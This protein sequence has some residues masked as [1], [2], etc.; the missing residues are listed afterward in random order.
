MLRP[1]AIFLPLLVHLVL[2]TTYAYAADPLCRR[3]ISALG[4]CCATQCGQCGGPG[5]YAKSLQF[6]TLCC[7]DGV[8]RNSPSCSES[9][10]PCKLS[11]TP[12]TPTP[13]PRAPGPNALSSTDGEWRTAPVRSG[14]LNKRHEAC[15][16]MVNGLVVL[17]GGRGINKPPSIYNPKT[18]VWRT[19]R[20]PGN[21]V[22]L[23][24][25][26]C[27][28][29]GGKVWIVSSW[30][31]AYPFERNNDKIWIYDVAKNS[32]S[33]KQG[34][35]ADR[36]RGGAAA[37]RRGNWIYVVAGNR[38][39]HGKHAQSLTWMDAYNWRTGKWSNPGQYPDM[40]GG[41]RDHTVGALVNGLLCVASGRDGGR[42][43][44]F[45]AVRRT[46]YCY[47]FATRKWTK[48]ENF[49][50]ARAGAMA[51]TTCDGKMMIA[52]GEGFGKAF[53]R[54]DVFD[55]R[56]WTRAPPLVRARHGSGLAMARCQR[57]AHIFIPS[58][59]GNQGGGPELLSTE[60][61]IPNGS[62]EECTRY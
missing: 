48:K 38:G 23:H 32:W 10:A 13:S 53:D 2:L 15:A 58:G 16:V 60:E 27:V 41:G 54:V 11:N 9:D 43:D 40:P 42:D 8:K 28:A 62:P 39:G 12:K 33:T 35:S 17:V 50:G 59:S 49:P 52:G 4:A 46:T 51:G 20:G 61:Y 7:A 36:S 29:I 56:R 47:D 5:C 14:Q 34:M 57:C 21:G 26:Q 30:T 55:G 25:F 44:F 45:V 3:G 31:G 1:A 18:K 6:S 24:H 22:E 19:G 37:V